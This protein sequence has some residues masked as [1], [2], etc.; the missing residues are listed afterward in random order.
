MNQVAIQEAANV[1]YPMENFIGVWWS[2]SEV[3]VLPSGDGANGY[4]SANF[5]YVGTDLPVFA[6]LQKYVLDA[7]KGAGDGSNMGVVQYNR[8][9]FAAMLAAEAAKNAQSI[10]GV[11]D[12][13]AA[14]MRDGMESLEI[15]ADTYAANGMPGF[16]PVI[17]VSCENHSGPGKALIQQWD[18]SAQ[19]WMA[20]TDYIESDRSVIDPL[21]TADAAA[22]A[23][24]SGITP[25]CM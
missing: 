14:M 11:A 5:T 22:Y 4:K 10:H 7:G 9:L 17:S 8:G 19:E 20:I 12:I 21:I 16:A 25:G 1:R 2:G 13:T 3:D 24:E 6:D 23:A 18:A 15:T